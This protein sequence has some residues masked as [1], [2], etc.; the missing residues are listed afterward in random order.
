MHPIGIR[1]L[2]AGIVMVVMGVAIAR[3]GAAV[4]DHPVVK[5]SVVGAL[6]ACF[7]ISGIRKFRTPPS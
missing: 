3:T 6:G 2:I 1:L 7:I 4:G 5:G